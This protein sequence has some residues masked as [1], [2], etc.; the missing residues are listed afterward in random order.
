MKNTTQSRTLIFIQKWAMTMICWNNYYAFFSPFMLIIVDLK[1]RHKW[2]KNSLWHKIECGKSVKVY[3]STY[4]ASSC[5]H[6][7]RSYII[8]LCKLYAW[9]SKK[10]HTLKWN[11][12]LRIQHL[13]ER[14]IDVVMECHI[15]YIVPTKIKQK[16]FIFMLCKLFELQSCRAGKLIRQFFH[17]AHYMLSSITWNGD[18]NNF[19]RDR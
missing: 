6:F 19:S 10:I 16:P 4:I 15:R 7:S 5:N 8:F 12:S 18:S 1:R 2:R 11:R 9:N 3:Q 13:P 17:A 14:I